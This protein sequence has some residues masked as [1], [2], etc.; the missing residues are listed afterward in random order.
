MD[1]CLSSIYYFQHLFR[2]NMR[3][4]KTFF[5]MILAA[6][7]LV[8]CGGGA[9]TEGTTAAGSGSTT[10]IDPPLYIA[11]TKISAGMSY[12]QIK[13]IVG[14]D[15]NG[16]TKNTLDLTTYIWVSGD[17]ATND[18]IQIAPTFR[19]GVLI[20]VSLIGSKYSATSKNFV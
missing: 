12:E 7:F 11:Y 3:I 6:S 19:N 16:G 1:N 4:L 2:I 8:A 13:N 14:Y 5:A 20:N 15:N 10:V 17:K 9:S 18:F